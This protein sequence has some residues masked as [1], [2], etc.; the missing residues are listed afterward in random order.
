MSQKITYQKKKMIA[1]M[2]VIGEYNT[3]FYGLKWIGTD[4]NWK[5]DRNKN[6]LNSNQHN[7]YYSF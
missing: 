2:G 7:L 4:Y 6:N 5:K 3:D 1:K